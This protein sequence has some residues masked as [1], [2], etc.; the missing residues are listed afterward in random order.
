[1]DDRAREM[2]DPDPCLSSFIFS[3]AHDKQKCPEGKTSMRIMKLPSSA[4]VALVLHSAHNASYNY[5]RIEELA[6][7]EFS[8]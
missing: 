2:D 5:C 3:L 7:E 4:Q 8:L 6:V 1:M